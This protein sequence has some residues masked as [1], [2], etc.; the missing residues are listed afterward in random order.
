[1]IELAPEKGPI[2]A[3]YLNAS[4]AHL[5][6]ATP[7]PRPLQRRTA[8]ADGASTSASQEDRLGRI[9]TTL[10][11]YGRAMASL[12]QTVQELRDHLMGP[13][14]VQDYGI[15][16]SHFSRGRGSPSARES[17]SAQGSPGGRTSPSTQGTLG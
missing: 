8:R 17:P 12:T 3:R 1:M 4:N 14:D 13:L 5:Q 6:D 15:H 10:E 9:E 11:A 7:A 2:T 16:S